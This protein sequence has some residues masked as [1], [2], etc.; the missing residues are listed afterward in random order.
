MGSELRRCFGMFMEEFR[1]DLIF[2]G[3]CGVLVALLAVI[4]PSVRIWGR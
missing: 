1:R 2:F 3:S 4:E